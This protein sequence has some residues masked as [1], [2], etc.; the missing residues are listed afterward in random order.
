MPPPCPS[1]ASEG[2][3]DV[4]P[5]VAN[6]ARV[7][8]VN[9]IRFNRRYETEDADERRRD[10]DPAGR[11]H[12][13]RAGE[14]IADRARQGAEPADRATRGRAAAQGLPPLRDPAAP[15][16]HGLF[17]PPSPRDGQTRRTRT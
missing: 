5:I 15:P 14:G 16:H 12:L 2:G 8:R 13:A 11:S 10:Q 3:D 1:P 7:T 4:A 9:W 6:P 17:L